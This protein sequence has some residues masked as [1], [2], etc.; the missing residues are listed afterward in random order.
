[1]VFKSVQLSDDLCPISINSLMSAAKST[2]DRF[3]YFF[4]LKMGYNERILCLQHIIN[5][6]LCRNPFLN[7]PV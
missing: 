1:M 2:K 6:I 5:L 4:Y 3:F 7:N